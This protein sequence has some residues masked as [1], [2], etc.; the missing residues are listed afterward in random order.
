MDKKTREKLKRVEKLLSD[1]EKLYAREYQQKA[2]LI[3][4]KIHLSK[5]EVQRIL[6]KN[7]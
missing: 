2:D 1:A 4:G 5:R 6:E 7:D 3:Y